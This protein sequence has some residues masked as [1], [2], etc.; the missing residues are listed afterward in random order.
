[1]KPVNPGAHDKTDLKESSSGFFDN[2]KYQAPFTLTVE[3][4][5]K[6]K[7]RS[8]VTRGRPGNTQQCHQAVA[9]DFCTSIRISYFRFSMV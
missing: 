6:R 1:M 7:F 9:P 8:V 4:F 5:L 2:S 3:I